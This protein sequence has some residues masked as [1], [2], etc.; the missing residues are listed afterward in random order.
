MGNC[1]AEHV[2]QKCYI[3]RLENNC[4]AH[5]SAFGM[6]TTTTLRIDDE[7]KLRITSAAERAGKTAHA[8]M[9]DAV[10]QTVEQAEHDDEF[11][12]V[13]DAR[14]AKVLAT[15]KTVPWADAQAY[16]EARARG[17]GPH[18]PTARKLGR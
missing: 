12:R 1:S 5:S 8:F 17:E 4:F 11:H 18:K 14:W 13:A 7:L 6:S 16:L 3:W 2:A 10:T 9:L 15:G